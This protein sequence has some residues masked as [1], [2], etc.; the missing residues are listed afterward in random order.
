[1]SDYKEILEKE[2]QELKDTVASV[3]DLPEEMRSKVNKDIVALERSVALGSYDEKYEKV[4]R[5]IE[6]VLKVPWKK[7]TQDTLDIQKTIEI[8]EKHHYGMYDVKDRFLE[9]VSVLKLRNQNFGDGE[10]RAP[11]YCLLV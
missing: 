8:F 4:S 1:M 6:W 2:I 10:F 11:F 7:E 9:Y 3:T 5:Y